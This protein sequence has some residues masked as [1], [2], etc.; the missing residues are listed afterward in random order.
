MVFI[1]QDVKGILVSL[2]MSENTLLSLSYVRI[3]Q[4]HIAMPVALAILH[5]RTLEDYIIEIPFKLHK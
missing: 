1:I 5:T 3:K 4:G 2:I